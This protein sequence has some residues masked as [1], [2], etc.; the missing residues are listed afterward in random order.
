MRMS[1]LFWSVGAPAAVAAVIL[2]GSARQARAHAIDQSPTRAE[3]QQSPANR[4]EQAEE[5][6]KASSLIGMKVHGISGE[7]KIGTIHDL[8]IGQDGRVKYV[9]V[10]FGGFLGMGDKLFAVPFEAIDFVKTDKDAFARI[11]VTAETLKQKQGFN[12]EVWPADADR[13]FANGNLRRQANA[14]R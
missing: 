3:D 9:A 6:C 5:R 13:S 12:K 1:Q 2:A 14:A 7:E 8:V 4:A 10:A 11:D